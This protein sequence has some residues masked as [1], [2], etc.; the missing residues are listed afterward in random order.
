M[1]PDKATNAAVLWDCF[2][3]AVGGLVSRC[4]T[5]DGDIVDVGD[6]VLGNLWL[7][8]VRHVVMEDGDRVSPTHREFGETD[9]TGS[10]KWCSR[11][12]FQREHIRHIQR[13]SQAFRRR[14]DLRTAQ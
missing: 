10:G 5:S 2:E 4:R 13:T 7:K 9:R 6:G 12:M 14:H 11:G 3:G 1:L 8:D